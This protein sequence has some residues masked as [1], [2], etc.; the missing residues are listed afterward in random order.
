MI[1]ALFSYVAILAATVPAPFG[2]RREQAFVELALRQQV[3]TYAQKHPRPR[4]TPSD[5]AFGVDRF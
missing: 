1:R 2:T 4:L 5:R 3:A